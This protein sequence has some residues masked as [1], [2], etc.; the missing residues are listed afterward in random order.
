VDVANDQ[1][2]ALMPPI[3]VLFP[4]YNTGEALS[5]ICLSLCDHMR[6]RQT[7]VELMTP[8]SEPSGRRPFTRDAV[9]PPLRRV[10]YKFKLLRERVDALL[11]ARFLRWVKPCE[12]VY[13]WPSCPISV[14]RELKRR[15]N[16]I[17]TERINCHTAVAKQILDDAYARLGRPPAHGITEAMIATEREELALADHIFS[18]SPMVTAALLAQGVER[19]KVL[20]TSYGWEPNRIARGGGGTPPRS[21]EDGIT[22]AFVGGVCVRKGAHLLLEAWARAGI[23]G[24][25]I[26]AGN[27]EPEIAQICAQHLSRP[28][29][30]PLGHVRDIGTVF[31]AADI[32]AFPTIEEG[33]PLVTYEAMSCSLPLLVSP[34]GAGRGARDGQEGLVIDPYDQEGWIHALRKFAS[35]AELRRT[36]G[37]AGAKRAREF[38]WDNVAAQRRRQLLKSAIIT[39]PSGERAPSPIAG[40]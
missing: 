2:G 25:L 35:D 13:L 21:A 5:H 37:Q 6:D 23:K 4:V 11:A 31:P 1:I 29:V 20:E 9:P 32:F 16:R 34:M 18:P 38:T 26:L 39:P 7:R 15:G 36:F 30:Q 8:S 24:R 19:Q 17:V 40:R 27:V 12:I 22:V 14:F 3:K 28:D 10:T 33:D